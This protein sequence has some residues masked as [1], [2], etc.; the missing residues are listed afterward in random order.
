MLDVSVGGGDALHFAL[1]DNLFFFV[2]FVE[3]IEEGAAGM[4]VENKK[5]VVF[6]L[7]HGV[8]RNDARVGANAS[9]KLKFMVA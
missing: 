2:F 6:I 8:D 1:H 7:N 3:R 4:K 9:V 5:E